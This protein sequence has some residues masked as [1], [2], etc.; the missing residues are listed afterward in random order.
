MNADHAVIRRMCVGVVT[1]AI[2]AT[3]LVTGVSTAS[4]APPMPTGYYRGNVTTMPLGNAVWYGKSFHRGGV[5]NNTAIG[6]AFPGRVYPGR[7]VQDGTSVIVVDYRGTA[8][9][10]VRDE[11]RPDGHGGYFGRSLTGTTELLRFRLTR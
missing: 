2:A 7:S 9:G 1:G 4:A 10:F 5:V 3:G 11:L 8:V 6:W